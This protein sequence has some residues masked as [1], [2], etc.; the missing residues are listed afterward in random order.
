VIAEG[1]RPA[2]QIT[3][4]IKAETR[5][6]AGRKQKKV[7]RPAKYV[8]WTTPF[9]WSGIVAAQAKVGWG[10]TDIVRELQRINYDFYQYLAVP[11][12]MG[13]IETVGGF[14]QWK[15]SVLARAAKGN[16]PGHNKRGGRGILVN[17]TVFHQ[18]PFL[19]KMQSS[20]PDIVKAIT[21]QLVDLRVAGAPLSLAT[22]RCIIIAII[23]EKA[24]EIFEHRFKDGSTF[25]VS[26]SFC[27]KFLDKT[28]AWSMRKGTKAAQKLPADAEEKCETAFLR[29]A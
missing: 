26:D 20:Y 5:K 23:R 24:P 8:N 16:I 19:N 4:K 29:R 18:E 17:E 3:Q 6:P 14:S 27:R 7:D 25:Q 21:S 9:A 2:R 12:V 13:W 11:T 15:P 28:M 1:S 22:V 10:Y